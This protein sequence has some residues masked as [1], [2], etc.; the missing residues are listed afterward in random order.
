MAFCLGSLTYLSITFGMHLCCIFENS[1]VEFLS[2]LL[3]QLICKMLDKISA[4]I[5]RDFSLPHPQPGHSLDIRD[6]YEQFIL[7][8][9]FLALLIG[10]ID[11]D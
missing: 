6:S 2:Y 3:C 1:E 10:H 4:I 7:Y 11:T 8:L 9:T 5:E